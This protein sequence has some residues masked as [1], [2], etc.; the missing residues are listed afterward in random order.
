VTTLT[1]TL[2]PIATALLEEDEEAVACAQL[3]IL[4]LRVARRLLLAIQ[5][6]QK[7]DI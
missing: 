4:L 7:E 5:R 3:N 2:T 1:L 6:A